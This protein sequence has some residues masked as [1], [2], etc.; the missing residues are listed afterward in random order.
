MI[1]ICCPKWDLEEN[2]QR[3]KEKERKRA[4]REQQEEY[5]RK[6]KERRDKIIQSHKSLIQE[7]KTLC[8]AELTN[9]IITKIRENP[10]GDEG[11][12]ISISN[13]LLP[14]GNFEEFIKTSPLNRYGLEVFYTLLNYYKNTLRTSL[15]N[16][17]EMLSWGYQKENVEESTIAIE[18]IVSMHI[19]AIVWDKELVQNYI[20]QSQVRNTILNILS[21]YYHRILA[22]NVNSYQQLAEDLMQSNPELMWCLQAFIEYNNKKNKNPHILLNSDIF[23]KIK[24]IADTNNKNQNSAIQKI[25]LCVYKRVFCADEFITTNTDIPQIPLSI[26]A[27]HHNYLG[28][29]Y[30]EMTWAEVTAAFK[31]LNEKYK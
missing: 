24:E 22:S 10:F 7:W 25:L 9:R 1:G 15:L 12:S 13:Y 18:E 31:E 16:I 14:Y 6:Y 2:K 26:S 11:E 23:R 20:K 4:E 21:F 8:N 29:T 28:E 17:K 5:S 27:E 19:V 30:H 3:E